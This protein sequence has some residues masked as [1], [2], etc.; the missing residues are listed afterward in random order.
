MAYYKD[1]CIYNQCVYN[2]H[3]KHLFLG[4]ISVAQEEDVEQGAYKGYAKDDK[5]IQRVE[6][7]LFSLER[8]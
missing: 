6:F 2:L 8:Y 7:C 4:E 1:D 5:D 3:G